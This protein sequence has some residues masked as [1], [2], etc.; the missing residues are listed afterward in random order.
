MTNSPDISHNLDPYFL[1]SRTRFDLIEL[2]PYTPKSV[3]EVG[4]GIGKTGKAI[5][6]KYGSKVIGIDLS[7]EA[8]EVATRQGCWE[9]LIVCDLDRTPIPM[10]IE[11]YRFDCIMYPDVLE[12]LKSPWN[13]IKAH[14]DLLNPSGVM[15]ASIPNIRH[16]YVMKDLLFKGNWTYTEM[17]ILDRT[18]L[19]FFTKKTMINLFEQANLKVT[20]IKPR[21]FSGPSL[22]KSINRLN[23]HL[24]E[25][26]LTVQYLICACRK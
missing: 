9:K 8:I 24:L 17:G 2:I 10:E 7:A 3:L 22:L 11:N 18:H 15:I 26:F 1:N 16:I 13:I 12:H 5:V 20:C 4:C 21:S 25:E 19:R 6:D 14:L 23:H